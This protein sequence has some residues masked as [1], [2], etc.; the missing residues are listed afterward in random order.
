M[1]A[2]FRTIPVNTLALNII[3]DWTVHEGD[4]M[5]EVLLLSLSFGEC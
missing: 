3:Q 5:V 4:T 1:S 2:D